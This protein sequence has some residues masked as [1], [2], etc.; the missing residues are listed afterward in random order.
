MQLLNQVSGFLHN[1]YPGLTIT[2]SVLVVLTFG[3]TGA[4]LIL[5]SLAI[6]GLLI[7]FGAPAA[8]I[9]TVLALMVIF[10]IKPLRTNLVTRGLMKTMKG[11]MPKISDTERIALEAGVVWIEKDL[12]SGK[13]DFKKILKEPY[14]DLT[15]EEKAFVNGPVERL[16][17][18]LD[19][20]QIW[21]TREIP[22]EAWDIIKK[23]RFLGM[24]I[25]KKYGG[26]GFSALAHSAVIQKVAARC[27]PACVTIMVPNSL[28]PAELI[29]HYGTDEQKNRLLPKLACGDEIP[30]FALTE[31][32]AGSDAGSILA[33]GVLFKDTDG[34][35]KM[36]LNWNKRYITLANIATTLGLA[37]KL[38]DPENLLGKGPNLG[39]TCALIPSSTKGVVLGRRH[40]P[41]GVPFSNCPTQGNDVVVSAEKCI[42]GGIK[43]AGQGWKMLMECLA[44]GRGISLPAQSTGGA[45][46]FTR[47]ASAYATVRKQFGVS[48]GN[49]EGI[50]EPLAR[51]AGFNYLM[52]AA[53]RFVCGALDQGIKPP[54]IT[55]M[56]KYN[57]TELMRKQVIDT[58]DI[59]GGAA[60]SRGP[61]NLV[62]HAYIGTPIGITVEGAN[63]MTRT[64]I[65]FGQG[66]LRAHPYA[67]KEVDA[68]VKG[69]VSAFDSAFWGHVGHVVRNLFRS[70]L[71]SLTRGRLAISPVGGPT[72]QYYRKLAWASATFAI[73]SD[74]AMGTLGGTLKTREK[75]T[76]RFAD[77]LSWMFLATC[78]LRRFEAE[79][80]KAEDLPFV[81]F[82]LK[83]ALARIQEGFN[84]IFK[85]I[86]SPGLG[87][88][89]AGPI[90]LWAHINSIGSE[91]NDKITNQIAKLIQEDSPQRDRMTDGIYYSPVEGDALKRLD[92]TFKAVKKAGE[93]TK[94][95]RKAVSAGTLPKLKGAALVEEALKKSVITQDDAKFLQKA[96]A[97]RLDAIQVDDYSQEE[98]LGQTA[99][100]HMAKTA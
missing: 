49:F 9:Y 26:L 94:K 16:C 56:A 30:C 19:D 59:M 32:T 81:H 88:L 22:K 51:V 24:I 46:L 45:K 43:G 8:V 20:W 64:L 33:N 53:R 54:V 95:I 74:M 80:R 52:E 67:F 69:D 1:G 21:K 10:N 3:Y 98:Y 99:P 48:V 37:F 100:A 40:D 68:I 72:A 29:S 5:W 27:M 91:A 25:S 57:Q 70:V 96:E 36:R 75:I 7:G 50:G 35:L 4:P 42:V 15:D 63:I 97:M 83:Y 84:G 92:D 60:I 78:T 65:I 55:A 28:G 62:G 44:A 39:I 31:P 79:G 47:A 87:W 85:N 82:S 38:Q 12:F 41:L 61:R 14:P 18:V 23:E 6:L 93:I 89:F 2:A 90:S 34:E 77:V 11:F 66:A 58:M 13:P 76:G 17:A 71:L 73:M 86:N